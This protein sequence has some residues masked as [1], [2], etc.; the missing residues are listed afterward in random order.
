MFALLLHVARFAF[1]LDIAIHFV[2]DKDSSGCDVSVSLRY[3]K[4]LSCLQ[5]DSSLDPPPPNKALSKAQHL[6]LVCVY[7]CH[8][9]NIYIPIQTVSEGKPHH[10]T[11]FYISMR[12]C[13][14]LLPSRWRKNSQNIHSN[15]SD[16]TK[17]QYTQRTQE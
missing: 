14:L 9:L 5:D 7:S 2:Y 12:P 4:Q 1:S 6:T 16:E 3:N 11:L 10:P 8:L 15:Q 17:Q 13:S